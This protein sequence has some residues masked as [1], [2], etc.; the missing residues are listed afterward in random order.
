MSIGAED[1]KTLIWLGLTER[2]AKVYLALLQTGSAGAEAISKLSLVHRQEIYRVAACLQEMGLVE[3]EV[4]SPI[5]FS[6]VPVK[7]ALEIMVNQKTNEF[8]GGRNRT[9]SLI[10]RFNRTDVQAS[11]ADKPYFT[12]VSGGVC[13]RKLQSALEGSCRNVKIA[14]TLRLF[15]QGFT[16][17]EDLV[18]IAL[19]KKVDFRVVTERPDGETFPKWVIQTLLENTPN[20][21]VR[22]AHENLPTSMSLYDDRRL[23]MAVHNLSDLRG[24]QLWSNSESLIVLSREYFENMWV[25]SESY[26]AKK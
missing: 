13:I 9:R 19:E 4:T 24:A 22:I 10:D 15:C 12:L 23:C 1:I 8:D 18:K 7:Q 6:A 21:K 2:Q 17:H 16:I 20:F 14:C 3:T 5:M 26:L 25:Q 11:S